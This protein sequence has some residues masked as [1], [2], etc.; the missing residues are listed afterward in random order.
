MSLIVIWS[1][2]DK[3]KIKMSD[4]Y[5]EEFKKAAPYKKSGFENWI[6]ERMDREG[7]W[8]MKYARKIYI[9]E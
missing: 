1:N 8:N 4:E 7:A 9:E 5:I 6:I 3:E 2:G